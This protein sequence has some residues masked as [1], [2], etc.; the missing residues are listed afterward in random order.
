MTSSCSSE[1]RV[2]PSKRT[3]F[4]GGKTGWSSEL[5]VS[6]ISPADRNGRSPVRG[7]VICVKSAYF[8]LRVTVFARISPHLG[9]QRPHPFKRRIIAVNVLCEGTGLTL[10]QH[11][12]AFLRKDL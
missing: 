1:D 3:P 11:P 10:R 5:M 2:T 7:R 6:S 8:T 12:I 4:A 9:D